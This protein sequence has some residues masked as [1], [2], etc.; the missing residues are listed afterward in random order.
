MSNKDGEG[1]GKVDVS[2]IVDALLAGI[3]D[4]RQDK[5]PDWP[6]PSEVQG[7][8]TSQERFRNAGLFE[9]AKLIRAER[10]EHW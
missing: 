9:S 8:R 1:T 3:W 4:E 10:D 5:P 2:R 6:D 7:P